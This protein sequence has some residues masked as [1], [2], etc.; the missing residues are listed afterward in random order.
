[1]QNSAPKARKVGFCIK[2]LHKFAA[3]FHFFA[4]SS[5]WPKRILIAGIVVVILFS[6]CHIK[7]YYLSYSFLAE[8]KRYMQEGN[9]EKA[10]QSLQKAVDLNP[11]QY[12]A[13]IY[14]SELYLKEGKPSLAVDELLRAADIFPGDT[15]LLAT[16]KKAYKKELYQSSPTLR[17]GI[18]SELNPL[19]SIKAIEPILRYLSRNLNCRIMLFLLLD[20]E[21][22]AR[23][24][25]EE[26]L[27]IAILGPGELMRIEY[28]NKVLPLLLASSNRQNIERSVIIASK[29]AGIKSIKDLKGKKFAFSDKDSFTGY[30]VPRMILLS[31]G[32]NPEKDFAQVFFMNSQ[33]EVF[34]NLVEGKVD[35][36]AMAEYVFNYLLSASPLPKE[37]C[38]IARSP[39]IPANVLV[40]RKSMSP[41]LISKVKSILLDYSG[42]NRRE[43]IFQ[44][45]TRLSVKEES[46]KKGESMQR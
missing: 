14:L 45:Y 10:I 11:K 9:S 22:A 25:E 41:E 34:L 17:V 39:E 40:V 4:S 29:K 37:V 38:I 6:L 42:S 24:L 26:K 2:I 28:Q 8:G 36:G 20:S 5:K 43:G 32:I 44:E 3:L 21:S 30:T 7:I 16:L 31:E 23:W 27:D 18:R 1:M 13:Y 46:T 33:E 12:D 15:I 19:T 35:A